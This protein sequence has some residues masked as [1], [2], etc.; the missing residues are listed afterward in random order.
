MTSAFFDET[1]IHIVKLTEWLKAA[2]GDGETSGIPRIVLP[3][4]QRGSVWKPHQVMDLWDTLLRGLPVGSM[5]ASEANSGPHIDPISRKEQHISADNPALSLLDGQQRTL[6]M[7]LAWPSAHRPANK[8]ESRSQVMER[9]I[10]IDLGAPPPQDKLFRYHFTTIHQPFG[11]ELAGPSGQAVSK[12]SRDNRRKALDLFEA[13]HGE[14]PKEFEGRRQTLWARALPWHGALPIGLHEVLRHANVQA[15]P[16]LQDYVQQQLEQQRSNLRQGL[17]RAEKDSK[18]S[19]LCAIIRSRLEKLDAFDN[20]RVQSTTNSLQQALARLDRLHMP[21]IEVPRE[22]FEQKAAVVHEPVLAV[23]FQRIGTG[24]TALSNADYVYAILKHYNSECHSLVETALNDENIAALFDQITL[25]TT[26]VRL[27][28]AQVA[29]PDYVKIDKQ[30][31]ARLMQESNFLRSFNTNIKQDGRF[32]TDLKKILTALRYDKKCKDDIGF[33]IH[34]LCLIDLRVLEVMLRWMQQTSIENIDPA[35]RHRLIRFALYW[36][37]AVTDKEKA[38]REM[39]KTLPGVVK[40]GDPFPEIP[41]VEHLVE[42]KL[43]L[44]MRAPK[45]YEDEPL[46]K[47][48]LHRP[49][50]TENDNAILRGWQRFDLASLLLNES[51]PIDESWRMVLEPAIT[52][53]RRFSNGPGPYWNYRHALLL[54]LQRC[55]VAGKFEDIPALPGS[56]DGTPYDYDHICPS[57]HWSGWTGIAAGNRIMDFSCG[58]SAENWIGNSIG[59][60]RVWESGDNRSLSDASPRVRLDFDDTAEESDIRTNSLIGEDERKAWSDCSA[61]DQARHWTAERS[62]AFQLA[63]E[64]RIFKLYKQLHA[65]LDFREYDADNN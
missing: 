63:I 26:A 47:N 60:V 21:V 30:Q 3:M 31:F 64:K 28:A 29:A 25:V 5:M 23:L 39:F 57:N 49:Q 55:Y 24:G 17:E 34:A 13:L 19:T 42:Q 38:S 4:I 44:P 51:K 15:H 18:D 52:L 1:G 50:P 27:T 46:L 54:W 58:N 14:L 62:S 10:W 20:A 7:L 41:L 11:Y 2:C 59:N 65:D 40:T 45:F 37:L 53:Y 9:G 36:N 32:L 48:M 16:G 8:E 22:A 56:E 61:G 12:L 33:P 43:A 35:N 6:A